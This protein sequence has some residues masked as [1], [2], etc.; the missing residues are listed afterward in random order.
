MTLAE[1]CLRNLLKEY[2]KGVFDLD[3]QRPITEPLDQTV[4][5]IELIASEYGDEITEG[6]GLLELFAE[7]EESVRDYKNALYFPEDWL[8]AD[9]FPLILSKAKI[10]R[11]D[12]VLRR[13]PAYRLLSHPTSTVRWH[14]FNVVWFFRKHVPRAAVLPLLYKD[15]ADTLGYVEQ[16][17]GLAASFYGSEEEFIESARAVE[18]PAGFEEQYHRR[19][20]QIVERKLVGAYI[21][22]FESRELLV[23]RRIDELVLRLR[24]SGLERAGMQLALPM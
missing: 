6:E 12:A 13:T 14:A 20:D 18:A 4:F 24:C 1:F 5:A 2:S 21:Q 9:M 23:R 15:I 17:I 8:L 16:A 3:G 11:D 7:A 10:R 22:N 19:L